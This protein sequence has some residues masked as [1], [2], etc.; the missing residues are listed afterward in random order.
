MGRAVKFQAPD[1]TEVIDRAQADWHWTK[2]QR[3]EAIRWYQRFLELVYDNP[4]GRSFIVSEAADQ[5]WHTHITFTLRYRAYCLA[6]LG[7]YLEHTPIMDPPPP[8]PALV[9]FVRATY[10]N[11]GWPLPRAYVIVP[12]W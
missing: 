6:I 7:F 2:A 8:S 10:A 1:L 9:K 12:C 5:L 11:K 3:A 4:G